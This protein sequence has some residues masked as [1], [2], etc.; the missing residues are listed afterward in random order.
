VLS[1][2]SAILAAIAAGARRGILFRGGV[3]VEQLAEIEV[4]AM[5]KTGTLTTGE[6]KVESVTSFPPGK[7]TELTEL[8]YALERLSTHPLARAVTR[9]GRSQKLRERPLTGYVSVTGCGLEAVESGRRI[10][11]GKRSWV[12]EHTGAVFEEPA[13]AQDEIVSEVW[14]SCDGLVGRMRLRDEIRPE[15]K[16]VVLALHERGLRSVVLTGDRPEAAAHLQAVLAVQ[17]VR[18]G[19]KPEEKLQFITDLARSGKKAAM[20]G[21]GINDAPSLAAAHVGV[22]MGARGSDA[23]LEQADLVLMHDRLENFLGAFDISIAAR[24]VIRQN[25]A[26]S[27]GVIVLMVV[28]ALAGRIPLTLGVMGHEG[29]TLVVV[30]NSLR[31]LASGRPPARASE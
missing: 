29:S 2:P 27:L 20:I 19:L 24:R 9:F 10:R 4:V 25:I 1:V 26:I 17:E 11:L 13:V 30:L 21:D 6:L 14:L 16:G 22:A 28:L 23:A 12:L 7:E 8:A 15:S 5:D 31:L 18:A 3:A